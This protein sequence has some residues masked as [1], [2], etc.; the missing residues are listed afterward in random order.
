MTAAIH[1]ERA[2]DIPGAAISPEAPE[3]AEAQT[4]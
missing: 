2:F 3:G 4:A 1:T